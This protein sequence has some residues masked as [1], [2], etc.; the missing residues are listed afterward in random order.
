MTESSGC[1][2]VTHPERIRAGTSG[3]LLPGTQARVVDPETGADVARGQPGELWFRGPQ[4]FKGY[5]NQP[6]ATAAT[7][8]A[9]G[10]VRTG[11]IA[12]IDAD[13]YLAITDRLKE[14]IKVKG[15][16]VAPA[17]LEAL[18]LT[19]PG[20]ADAAVIGRGDD[21]AG[22]LPVAYVVARGAVLP[23]EIRD[24]VA[25]RVVAYKQLGE[26]VLCE[27]IPKS[28]AGKIL[29]RVLRATDAERSQPAAASAPTQTF[30]V[31]HAAQSTFERGLRPFF[32]YRGLGI[33]KATGGQVVAHVIRA[34]AGAGFSSQPHRHDTQFQMV[35]VLKG[36]I[37]FDYDGPGKVRLEAGS[38][39][40]Q[41]PGLRHRELGHSDD[42]EM[43]EVVMP[44]D[45]KTEDV[46]SVQGERAGHRQ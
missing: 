23:A 9:D 28:A 35:Y 22:E 44:A 33:D 2:A 10:W 45:F 41:P 16:Q 20:V 29:R 19:H 30:S 13:G 34:V 7:I 14:L 5:R 4:A 32:E 39:V 12:T 21:R 25:A 18:L 6:E 24:W 46:E 36:W 3:Q 31:S 11:D 42:L 37:E 38:C 27:A 1:V 15:F 26:V 43:L 8:T 17:E 40:Y